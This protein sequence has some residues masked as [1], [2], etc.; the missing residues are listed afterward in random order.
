MWKLQSTGTIA[1][2]TVKSKYLDSPDYNPR[3]VRY[4]FEGVLHVAWMIR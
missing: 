2:T 4:C 1:A 3:A